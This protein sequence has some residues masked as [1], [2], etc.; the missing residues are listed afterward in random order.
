MNLDEFKKELKEAKKFSLTFKAQAL[1][2][3]IFERY[4]SLTIISSISFALVGVFIALS[5]EKQFI[6]NI[7]LAY[8]S[9]GLFILIALVSLGRYLYLIRDDIKNI[10]I[11][12][13]ELP[14]EDWSKPLKIK[15]PKQDFWPEILYISLIMVIVLFVFSLI[16]F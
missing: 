8:S 13:R 10:S 15:K 16:N 7:S 6:K 4:R 14:N 2:V 1:Q 9:F 11:Q 3:L 12:I 5:F